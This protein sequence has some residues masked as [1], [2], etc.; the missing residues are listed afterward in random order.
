MASAKKEILL[1]GLSPGEFADE[2]GMLALVDRFR[3]EVID[4]VANRVQ[5][6]KHRAQGSVISMEQDECGWSVIEA[7]RKEVALLQSVEDDIRLLR[8]MPHE[9]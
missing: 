6:R 5:E 3:D 9:A 2:H 7:G 1:D 8:G 4:E